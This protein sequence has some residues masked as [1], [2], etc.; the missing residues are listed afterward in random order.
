MAGWTL[1]GIG[2]A[3]LALY[4]ARKWPQRTR[5]RLRADPGGL[6][7]HKTLVPRQAVTTGYLLAS[8]EEA[9]RLIRAG[10]FSEPIDLQL[11]TRKEA[12]AFVNALGLGTTQATARFRAVFG[13]VVRRALE[14]GGA[15]LVVLVLLTVAEIVADRFTGRGL[16]RGLSSAITMMIPTLFPLLI[17]SVLRSTVEVGADGIW[18]SRGNLFLPYDELA[19]VTIERSDIVLARKRGRPIRLGF[20]GTSQQDEARAACVKRIEEASATFARKRAVVHPEALLSPSGRRASEWVR[21]LRAVGGYRSSVIPKDTLWRIV[22]DP[23]ADP[24]VRAGAAVAL[25]G[26]LGLDEGERRRLRVASQ[27]CAARKLRVAFELVANGEA[28]DEVVL[29]EAL[30]QVAT[31]KRV[32]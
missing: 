18:V 24:P 6:R 3:L 19:G 14:G 4:S 20:G 26:V 13:G 30:E 15:A 10:R 8:P 32:E 21:A 28:A 17:W 29:G 1:G 31:T 16:P 11:G 5:V 25:S 27:A 23:S 2:P 7:I 9:V 12:M 22:E